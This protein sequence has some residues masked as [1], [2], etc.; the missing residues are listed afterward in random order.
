MSSQGLLSAAAAASAVAQVASAAAAAASAASPGGTAGTAAGEQSGRGRRPWQL[1]GQLLGHMETGSPFHTVVGSSPPLGPLSGAG[2]RSSSE[3]QE[4]SRAGTAPPRRSWDHLQ[5]EHSEV[6]EA[7]WHLVES[8]FLVFLELVSP[9]SWPCWGSRGASCSH[10]L[11]P[12]PSNEE[13]Y[14]LVSCCCLSLSLYF[15]ALCD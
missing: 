13:V 6:P 9:F 7:V 1:V 8:H 5:Q 11:G 15:A 10:S 4:G 2:E 14:L 3:N 12:S